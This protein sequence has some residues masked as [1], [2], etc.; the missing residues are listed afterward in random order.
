MAVGIAASEHEPAAVDIERGAGDVA[1]LVGGKEGDRGGDLLDLPRPAERNLLDVLLPLRRRAVD[2]PLGA[3]LTGQHVPGCDGIHTDAMGT[4]L[5]CELLR[6]PDKPGLGSGVWRIT[7]LAV[8]A[9]PLRRDVDDGAPTALFHRLDDRLGAQKR[10][11][12]VDVDDSVPAR[13][14]DFLDAHLTL[15]TARV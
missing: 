12:E 11:L 13:L 6:Q 1:G 9:S 2:P 10:A 4:Q 14:I 3:P 15:F 7:E 5:P 8:G